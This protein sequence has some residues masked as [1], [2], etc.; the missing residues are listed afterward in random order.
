MRALRKTFTHPDI[1][2][3]LNSVSITNQKS[4]RLM[5]KEHMGQGLLITT[6]TPGNKVKTMDFSRPIFTHQFDFC[7][8]SF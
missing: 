7:M 2:L 8:F 5:E 3:V 4:G 1:S 6:E